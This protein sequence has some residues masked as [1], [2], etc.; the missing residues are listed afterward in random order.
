[1]SLSES[2]KCP[3]PTISPMGV[4]FRSNGGAFGSRISGPIFGEVANARIGRARVYP[5]GKS[6]DRDVVDERRG[7]GYPVDVYG[8]VSRAWEGGVCVLEEGLWLDEST[9]Y[10]NKTSRWKPYLIYNHE[11]G[12]TVKPGQVNVALISYEVG[13]YWGYGNWTETLKRFGMAF[14]YKNIDSNIKTRRNDGLTLV[15]GLGGYVVVHPFSGSSI[16][17]MLARP[18]DVVSHEYSLEDISYKNVYEKFNVARRFYCSATFEG[19]TES[20]YNNNWTYGSIT[21]RIVSYV[22]QTVPA[23]ST[24]TY[25]VHPDDTVSVTPRS[26]PETVLHGSWADN[27]RGP[28]AWWD[29]EDA[30][31]NFMGWSDID[32]PHRKKCGSVT[33][34]RSVRYILID[35]GEFGTNSN[36]FFRGGPIKI[37]EFSDFAKIVTENFGACCHFPVE[38]W[39]IYDDRPIYGKKYLHAHV[40]VY[41]MIVPSD[42]FNERSGSRKGL[43]L[44]NGSISYY[45]IVES[46][47]FTWAMTSE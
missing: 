11:L 22:N 29:I 14:D 1:M 20:W 4:T 28:W 35:P 12:D 33:I 27:W 23:G 21:S 36:E 10:R 40:E 30:T 41:A 17:C 43:L 44:T 24:A 18:D 25:T 34:N 3:R 19:H 8:A 15:S 9:P 7:Y 45:D 42:G 38:G 26:V 6:L 46:G 39:G 2:L 5:I 31:S 47:N 37:V 32:D 13:H 16:Q